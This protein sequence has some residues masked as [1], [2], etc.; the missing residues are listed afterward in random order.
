MSLTDKFPSLPKDI[1]YFCNLHSYNCVYK[2][3]KRINDHRRKLCLYIFRLNKH[4]T[5]KS[6][7]SVLLVVMFGKTG[8]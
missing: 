2:L 4:S 3:N 6:K 8:F 5:I 1:Y 7:F